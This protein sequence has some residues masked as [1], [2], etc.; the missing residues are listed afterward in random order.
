[1]RTAHILLGRDKVGLVNSCETSRAP[2]R[3]ERDTTKMN[4]SLPVIDNKTILTATSGFLG[5]GY[6]HT[7]N[8]YHGCSFAHALCGVFCYAQHNV[9]VTKG[10]PWGLFGVKRDVCEAYCREYDAIKRPRRGPL[11][12]LRIYMSSASDP[13]PPQEHRLRLAQSLL[14]EMLDRPPDLVVI[15][16]HNTLV[17]R[18]LDLIQELS[19][20]C[21][22][23]VSLTVETDR[24]RIPGFPSHASSPHKRIAAL[25]AFRE[26]GVLTQAAVS[27]LLPLDD[28]EQ[29]A[30]DL[31]EACNRV[32]IDHYLV[33]D[34]SPRG[35]RTKRT[36]FPQ[37]LEDA[38]FGEWNRLGKLWEVKNVFD[39]VLGLGR[40]LVSREGF[41]AVGPN[42]K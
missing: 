7:I 20:R 9:W 36:K 42:R 35:L 33:G 4:S 26:R 12:P 2:D 34:G 14:R 37:L 6:T 10:R 32:I 38:G 40:V 22:L 15:Q 39:R 41:N 27:P 16:S 23:W 25:R 18:D 11:N 1:M 8:L 24:E 28:P 13:Y 29:F 21:E 19:Q 17:A 5:S 30:R 31:N 3:S